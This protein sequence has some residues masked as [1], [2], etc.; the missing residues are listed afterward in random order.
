MCVKLSITKTEGNTVIIEVLAEVCLSL[1]WLREASDA[2]HLLK[3]SLSYNLAK[4]LGPPLINGVYNSASRNSLYP[5][6]ELHFLSVSLTKIE[7]QFSASNSSFQ[8]VTSIIS[9]WKKIITVI[10]WSC[11]IC[12]QKDWV[13]VESRSLKSRVPRAYLNR[14]DASSHG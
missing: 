7:N 14:W 13:K 1:S 6:K 10:L 8:Y 4:W 2:F 3:S 11:Q 9:K 5:F 12:M